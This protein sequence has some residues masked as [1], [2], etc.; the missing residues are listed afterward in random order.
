MHP[1]LGRTAGRRGGRAR[2]GRGVELDPDL[3]TD[4]AFHANAIVVARD[5]EAAAEMAKD[6]EDILKDWQSHIEN[7]EG[8]LVRLANKDPQSVEER[9]WQAVVHGF[10]RAIQSATVRRQGRAVRLAIQEPLSVTDLRELKEA[11]SG[12]KKDEKRLAVSLVLEAIQKNEPI[13]EDA[14]GVLVGP[15][16]AAYL[17]ATHSPLSDSDCKKIKSKLDDVTTRELPAEPLAL[18]ASIRKLDCYKHLEMAD[19]VRACLLAVTDTDSFAKCRLIEEPPEKD[20][21]I[22]KA[23]ER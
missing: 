16:W 2:A 17:A 5:A 4:G 21:G 10:V 15:R 6:V 23:D 22:P 19:S 8:K 9:A 7:N 3:A 20:F 1:E 11:A 13:P 14:L 12:L 18:A